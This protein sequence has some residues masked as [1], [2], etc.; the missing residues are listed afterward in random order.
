MKI[1]LFDHPEI[2]IS[3]LPFTYTRPVAAIRCGILT[4]AEK[5]EHYLGRETS[6]LTEE[7][8]QEKYPFE[9]D[10]DNLL[11]NGATLPFAD[12][13]KALHGLKTGEG[14]TADGMAIA[15]R[16]GKDQVLDL[17]NSGF[18]FDSVRMTNF[19]AVSLRNTWD[20]FHLNGAQIRKDFTLLTEGKNPAQIEDRHTIVYARE[21]IFLE[22][23]VTIKASV[24]NAENGPI[25]LARNSEIQEGALIRGPFALGEGS[26][27]N[28]G[29]KI[30]G[31]ST[32]GPYCKVGGEVANSVMFGFSNKGHD[33]YMGNSVIGEWCNMGADTNTS[34]LKNNYMPVKVWS[35]G[36]ERFVNTGLQFC[37]LTMGDHSKCGINTM[38]NTGTV[39]GVSANIFGSGF[40]RA[41][42]PS[43][44]WGGAAGF[45][46]FEVN[47]A[48]EVAEAVMKR[49]NKILTEAD[50][51]VLRH[52]FEVSAKHRVWEKN[53]KNNNL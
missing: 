27:V 52:V 37:G 53:G 1:I 35:Y 3:L 16:L 6:F 26:V 10:E 50:R 36:K 25:Y 11:I 51:K 38:F 14:L 39:V 2:R 33:G 18:K 19:P 44:A 30:R 15:V 24:L 48:C 41:M 32:V 47:K 7:Y 8:L 21:N 42:T 40:P 29:A 46:T 43:F 17:I 28:M 34:N 22:E 5:W 4:V 9:P 20:I 23:G 12:L 45:T 13:V 49:R 31:D